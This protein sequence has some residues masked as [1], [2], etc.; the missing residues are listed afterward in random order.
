MSIGPGIFLNLF[1]L[2]IFIEWVKAFLDWII[3]LLPIVIPFTHKVHHSVSSFSLCHLGHRSGEAF[4]GTWYERKFNILLLS[5][6]LPSMKYNTT[7]FLASPM[8]PK[9]S[10]RRSFLGYLKW[11]EVIIE[12]LG[13]FCWGFLSW[14]CIVF[15]SIINRGGRHGATQWY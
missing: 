14:F 6:S 12:V 5:S 4:K 11:K 3:L 2:F 10:L 1:V 13:S 9:A 8:P 7:V 15:L